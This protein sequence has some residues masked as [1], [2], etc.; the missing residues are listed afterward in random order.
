MEKAVGESEGLQVLVNVGR[1]VGRREL[2]LPVLL[3]GNT[4]G[5]R[6]GN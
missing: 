6:V 1:A 3:L 4:D 5:E 2:G